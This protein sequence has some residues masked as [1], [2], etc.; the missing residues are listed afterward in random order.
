MTFYNVISGILF[1]GACQAFLVMLGTPGMWAAAVLVIT[2][3]NESVITSEL[4]ERTQSPV[5][6]KLGMKLLDFL[7]F[8]LLAWALLAVSPVTNTFNVDVAASLWGAGRPRWF[9]GLLTVYWL[10]TLC[11][12]QVAGQ[13]DSTKWATPFFYAMHVMALP[14]FMAAVVNRDAIDFASASVWPSVVALLV[15]SIYLVSKLVAAK[16]V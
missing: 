6:Y 15:V 9:W 8:G 10:V 2:I 11:W 4:I 7:A 13:R 3:L 1:F 12:N 5:P 14:A 16:T